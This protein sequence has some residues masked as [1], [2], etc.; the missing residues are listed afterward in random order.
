MWTDQRCHVGRPPRSLA[1]P[2]TRASLPP[3]N[4]PNCAQHWQRAPPASKMRGSRLLLTGWL[5]EE[6]G[7]AR[8][9][10]DVQDVGRQPIGVLLTLAF[11]LRHRKVIAAQYV[12]DAVEPDLVG[13]LIAVALPQGHHPRS[14]LEDLLRAQH[15]VGTNFVPQ[16]CFVYSTVEPGDGRDDARR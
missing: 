16:N 2:A 11:G 5:A 15:L 10:G 13:E 1:P 3:R 7:L 12:R 4:P 9:K 6:P 14:T 8:G